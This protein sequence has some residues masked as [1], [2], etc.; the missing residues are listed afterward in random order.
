[1]G[2]DAGGAERSAQASVLSAVGLTLLGTTCCALPIALVAIGAGGAMASLVSAVPWLSPLAEYK[3][4]TFSATAL[5]LGFG[6]VG[7]AMRRRVRA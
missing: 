1:M 3:A 5:L 6:L 4:V 2:S 7:L